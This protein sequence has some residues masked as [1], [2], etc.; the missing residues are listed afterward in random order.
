M[1]TPAALQDIHRTLFARL[2]AQDLFTSE[3]EPITPGALRQRDL[4]GRGNLSQQALIAWADYVLD[5]CLDQVRFMTGL[6]DF[7]TIK[8]RIEACLVFEATV[9]KQGV[10]TEALRGL[11]YLFLS[12]EDMPRG[13]FKAMLGLG[14]RSATD[15]LGALVKRGLLQSDSPQ[16][17]VR[18]GLPQHAL[19]FIFPQLWPEAEADVENA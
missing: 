15:A 10:R 8:T 12:G 13:D 9:C 16:G 17:K 11:H 19:R 6:L 5:I 2:P 7:D 3:H 4:D 18:F 1:Y 14:E